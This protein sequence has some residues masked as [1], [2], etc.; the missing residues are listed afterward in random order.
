ME[1]RKILFIKI[2]AIG[3]ILRAM[4][5]V[6]A[7]RRRYPDAHIT[8]MIAEEYVELIKNCPHIDE[9]LPYRKRRNLEDA[10][11]FLRV[12]RDI[13]R[14]KFDL[15]INLQNTR[16]FDLIARK[17]GAKKWTP[18]VEFERPVSGLKGVFTILGHADVPPEPP[19][20]EM[21]CGLQDREFAKMFL[22]QNGIREG[23]KIVGINPGT[24]WVTRQW[25]IESYAELSDRIAE[26][27]GAAVMIFGSRAERERAERIASMMKSKPVIAAGETTYYQ[28]GCLIDR[29]DAF[30]SNDSS[31]MH[32]AGL[33]GKPCVCIFGSTTPELATPPGEGHIAFHTQIECF[34]C[35]K[36]ACRLEDEP[37][38]CLRSIRV[39]DVFSEMDE[40]L[41]ENWAQCSGREG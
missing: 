27:A 2:S 29:C 16:R 38:L 23:Q 34:P 32:F 37:L 13:K 11:G 9:I 31:L 26:R 3:D 19:E 1:P 7:V 30:V 24:E 22:E 10:F 33:L 20:F 36:A 14:R 25:M 15:V 12:I 21:W 28:A 6:T 35:Y 17:S 5:G 41:L 18:V 4:P 40:K 8:W 39:D